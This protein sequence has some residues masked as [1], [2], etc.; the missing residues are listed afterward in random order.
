MKGN[1]FI[2]HP[3][4]LQGFDFLFISSGL[5][6]AHAKV[7]AVKLYLAQGAKQSS[8]GV[9]CHKS[10]FSSVIEAL[11]LTGYQNAFIRFSIL[12][13]TCER[14]EHVCPDQVAASGACMEA[15]GIDVRNRL[16][17]MTFGTSDHNGS[18]PLLMNNPGT[19]D[20]VV[21]RPFF[22]IKS[23]HEIADGKY[24]TADQ[25]GKITPKSAQITD[26]A[27][28]RGYYL[29]PAGHFAEG[30]T[31]TADKKRAVKGWNSDTDDLLN[32]HH[33]HTFTK[34][35]FFGVCR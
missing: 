18:L 32:N 4:L 33:Q 24:D 31:I 1:A 25:C 17:D 35:H 5:Q 8:A 21:K 20:S 15:A 2:K 22:A 23:Y 27:T 16:D 14:T 19:T 30:C 3:L 10:F 34:A 7:A 12:V 11:G 26:F 13:I 6:A 28:F 29:E 9:T